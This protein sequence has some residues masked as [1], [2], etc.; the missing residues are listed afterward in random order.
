MTSKQLKI[1]AVLSAVAVSYNLSTVNS[2]E[3]WIAAHVQKQKQNGYTFD[4]KKAQEVAEKMG[5]KLSNEECETILENKDKIQ[6]K[7]KY[8]IDHCKSKLKIK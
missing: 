8:K 5:L 1:A 3:E 6:F 7:E 2:E 4:N